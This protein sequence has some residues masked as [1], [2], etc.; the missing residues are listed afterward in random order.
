[1]VQ[2]LGLGAFTAVAPGSVPGQGAKIPQAGKPHTVQPK[3]NKKQTNKKTCSEKQKS[4]PL[5]HGHHCDDC[6][7]SH[8]ALRQRATLLRL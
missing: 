8:L 7:Q 2:L 6:F 5:T 1:M 4:P 3:Q